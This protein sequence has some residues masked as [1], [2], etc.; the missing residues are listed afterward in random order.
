MHA[1]ETWGERK[2]LDSGEKKNGSKG[3]TMRR[4]L[5]DGKKDVVREKS[6]EWK[7][8]MQVV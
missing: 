2:R 8:T 4:E 3:M 7:G 1:R 6:E 5:T